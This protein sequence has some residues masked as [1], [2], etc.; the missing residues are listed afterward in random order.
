MRILATTLAL[1]TAAAA[2]TLLVVLVQVRLLRRRREQGRERLASRLRP[3]IVRLLASDDEVDVPNLSRTEAPAFEVL[4]SEFLTK[5][6]GESRDRLATLF[7]RSG[8]VEAAERRC[9]ARDSSHRAAA[10][11]F[12]GAVGRGDSAPAIR[13]LLR[14]RSLE[15]RIATARAVGRIGDASDVPRLLA[16]LEGDRPVPFTTVADSLTHIGPS[17]VPALRTGLR[18]PEL[19]ARAVSAEVLGLLGAVDATED[20][21]A[22]LHPVEDYEVRIRC[23]RALGRIGTP[24]AVEQLARLLSPAEP[25]GLRAVA[26]RSL[27]RLGAPAVV[28]TL[29]AA[30]DDDVDLVARNVAEALVACGER[31]VA[32]LRQRRSGPGTGAAYATEA[33]ARAALA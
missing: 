3:V 10:V 26:V 9:R 14:D 30:L 1:A 13:P 11:D 21:L 16:R 15:V 7:V 28:P 8:A 2:F 12:L 17:A 5:V 32:A 33:L 24:R 29:V 20:L 31:G 22:H 27:G 25:A 23:A 6:R 19:L 18:A 4:A